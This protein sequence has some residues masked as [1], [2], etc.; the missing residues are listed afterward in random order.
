MQL[1]DDGLGREARSFNQSVEIARYAARGL[2]LPVEPRLAV[3][4]RDTRPQVGLATADRHANL[5]GAFAATAG[6][7][8]GR[9]IAVVDDVMT[10]GSTVAELACVL[11]QAGAASVDGWC[12][13]C[14]TLDSG[15]RI[16]QTAR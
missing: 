7:V 10:T 14:A 8:R 2:S 3:R 4:C 15:S 1:R 5:R 13:A 11:R 12:V 9:R 6:D 16:P